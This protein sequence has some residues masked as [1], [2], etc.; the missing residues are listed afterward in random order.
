[1][2]L[3]ERYLDLP[4]IF[5][6]RKFPVVMPKVWF[7]KQPQI[8]TQRIVPEDR[9]IASDDIQ[10]LPLVKLAVKV[11]FSSSSDL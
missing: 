8:S 1:M 10:W 4:S 2:R 3:L 9:S 7:K 6:S 11:P 5:S